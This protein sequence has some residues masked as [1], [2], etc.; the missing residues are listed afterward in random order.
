MK[1]AIF[2]SAALLLAAAIPAAHA[3]DGK[4]SGY[5]FGDYYYVAAADDAAKLSEK[6]NA[7]QLRR[8]YFN[9]DKEIDEGVSTRFRLEANDA[10]FGKG[11]NMEPFVKHAYI[12]WSK[13]VG[14]ADVY[15]GLS[16][17]PTWALS[18]KFW[19]YRSV[20]KTVLDLNKIGSSADLGVALKGKSG[21]LAYTAMVGNGPGKKP[22]NDNG[23]KIYGSLSFAA[24][25]ALTI[26]GYA[27]FNMLP[28]EQDQMTLKVF[29]GYQGEG[30]SGGVEAFSRVNKAAG[31]A[32][33][34][35]DDVT[36]SGVSLFATLPL[37]DSLKG[38]GRLDAVSNDDKDTTDMLIIAGVDHSPT[39]NVHLM[40]NIYV[41]LP[42][43][44][45]P[46]IQGRLT[47]YYKF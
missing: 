23:K 32:K 26:E 31:V 43:G 7:F 14:G 12:K 36:I 13:A 24:S 20:E 29:A 16:G 6:Q 42:D 1:K 8:V 45:D 46:S 4:V 9:Y 41:Q 39:K 40:P 15:L 3:A 37:G 34:A 38:F 10:G 33:Q 22:E 11:S 21:K 18:E 17:T 28:G 30:L 47:F 35:G 19:G 5:M 25:E 44:P 27:D 2:F